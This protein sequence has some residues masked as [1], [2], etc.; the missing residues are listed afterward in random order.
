MLKVKKV[1]RQFGS[2]FALQPITFALEPGEVIAVVGSNGAGKTTLIKCLLGLI[3]FE[4]QVTVGGVDV[5][6]KG[7]DARKLMGYLPQNPSFHGD[8]TVAETAVFYAQLRGVDEAR[9]R[10]AVEAVGLFE[11][12]DKQVGALSGGMKQRLALAVVQL[13]NPP[14]LILDEPATGLDVSARQELRTFILDGRRA[15]KATLLSTHWLEDVPST[16]DRV[17]VLKD[18]QVDFLGPSSAMATGLPE[19]RLRLRL[20]GHTADAAPVIQAAVALAEVNQEGEWL[21]VNCRPE[22]KGRVLQALVSSGITIL[23]FRM[24]PPDLLARATVQGEGEEGSQ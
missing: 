4:G 24:D 1:S 18:G 10:E 15:G 21:S 5:G 19:P 22:D 17:L 14:V 7:K 9:A 23:D 6:R 2:G 8:L 3:R 11:H 13:G 20:N 12:A 16:A